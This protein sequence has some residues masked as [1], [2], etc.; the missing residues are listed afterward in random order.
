VTVI[1]LAAAIAILSSF[2]VSAAGPYLI[3]MVLAL[4]LLNQILHNYCDCERG[5]EEG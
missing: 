5:R 4:T 3:L 1:L 2:A